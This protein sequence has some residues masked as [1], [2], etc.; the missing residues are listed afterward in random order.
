MLYFT[1][2]THFNHKNIINYCGRP[3]G[4]VKEMNE[5]I[6]ENWNNLITPDDEVYHLGDIGFGNYKDVIKCISQLNGKIHLI[7]GNHDHTNLIKDLLNQNLIMSCDLYKMI[8]VEGYDLFM[9]HFPM[10]SWTNK[11]RGSYMLHGHLHT[12][13]DTLPITP[14][15]YDVGVDKNDMKPV[16]FE[17]VIELIKAQNQ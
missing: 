6:I 11:E 1:S 5:A 3:Y 8:N 7:K 17:Q 13:N 15:H 9:C 4:S 16:S 14:D 10:Y 2:D 12:L